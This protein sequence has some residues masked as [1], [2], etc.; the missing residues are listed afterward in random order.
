M[1]SIKNLTSASTVTLNS[2][3]TYSNYGTLISNPTYANNWH[4]SSGTGNYTYYTYDEVAINDYFKLITD[5]LDIEIPEFTVFIRMDEVE[6]KA[7]LRE[8]LLKKLE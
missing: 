2:G 5:I 3:L 4:I 1:N 7:L 8:L 6:K